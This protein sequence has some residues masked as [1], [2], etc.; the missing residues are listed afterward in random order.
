MSVKNLLTDE[1]CGQ[2]NEISKLEV[3]TEESKTAIN[4]AGILMD[5]LND[6]QR[7]EL[8][9]RKLDMERERL[10]IERE[11]V[12]NEGKDRKIKNGIAIGTAVTGAFIT[13]GA[14]LLAYVYEERGTITS[15]PGRKSV[16]RA[17]NYFFKR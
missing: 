4:G 6:V 3:G 13:I 1:I 17:F 14:S 8:E 9:Q 7:L 10:E 2:V 15:M 11:K 5:K 16:D 12:E